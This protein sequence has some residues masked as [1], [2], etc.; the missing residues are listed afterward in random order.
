M[1]SSWMRTFATALTLACALIQPLAASGLLARVLTL[2]V[3][4]GDHEHSLSLASDEGH[5]HLVLSHARDEDHAPRGE[6]HAQQAAT[7]FSASDHVV[8]LDRGGDAAGRAASRGI[9]LADAGVATHGTAPPV[10]R[11][12]AAILACR[13][14]T[15]P[16]ARSVDFLRT[17]VLRL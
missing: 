13:F 1:K 9:V 6:P 10:A 16:Y 7:A 3:H 2:A 14:E 15:R 11:L 17:V 12:A 8:D 4:A 5:L